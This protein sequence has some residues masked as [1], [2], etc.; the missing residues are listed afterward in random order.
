M[1]NI[2]LC[3]MQNNLS[4]GFYRAVLLYSSM[5]LFSLYLFSAPAH[6]TEQAKAESDE[7]FEGTWT[8]EGVSAFEDNKQKIPFSVDSICCNEISS[9]III[10][11][12]E[13][14]FVRNSGEYKAKYKDAVKK[15]MFYYPFYSGWEIVDNKL[16]VH[17]GQDVELPTGGTRIRTIV[18]TYKQK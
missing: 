7:L 14:T 17:W 13:I 18:L 16:I 2:N 6:L 10:Q 9:E 4:S 5:I 8:L 12:D 3:I 11:Q 15:N 1:N